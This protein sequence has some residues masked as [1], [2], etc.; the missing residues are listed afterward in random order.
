MAQAKKVADIPGRAQAVQ[1]KQAAAAR[2]AAR[3]SDLAGNTFEDLTPPQK[4]KL[5]KQLAVAAGLIED[6]DD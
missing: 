6:S 2:R 1:A 4:D 5:L 3:V